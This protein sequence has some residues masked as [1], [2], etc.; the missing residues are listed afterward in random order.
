MA[1]GIRLGLRAYKGPDNGQLVW[2]PARRSTLYEML[3]HPVYAG[4]YVYGRYPC[5]PTR[6][7][8]GA[9]EVGP[10]DGPPGGVGVPAQGPRPGVHHLGAVRG[11]PA[12][13]GRERPGPRGRAAASGRGPTLLNGLGAVRPV[14]P[15]D[16]GPQRAADSQ[17][18]VRLRRGSSRSTAGRSARA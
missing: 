4:A 14:W 2:R 6:R 17:P 11:E 18:A 16:G 13:A 1:H 9:V 7:A 5:D 10:P 15:A 12:A 8:A 3:R